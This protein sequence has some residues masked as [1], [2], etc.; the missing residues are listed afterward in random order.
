LAD[1]HITADLLRAVARGDISPRI[2]VEIGIDH[3]TSLCP[4]CREEFSAWQAEQ[5]I[6][7]I[8]PEM[9]MHA[10]PSVLQRHATDAEAK[11]KEAERD[12]EALAAL[13][14]STR[15]TRIRR[16]TKR[17]RGVV[18]AGKLLDESKRI[19]PGEP[20]RAFDLAQAAETVLLQTRAVPGISDF[21]ARAAAFQANALRAQGHLQDAEARF[22]F[23]RFFIQQQGVTDSALIAE[24]DCCEAALALDQRRLAD[25]EKLLNRSIHMWT[26]AGEPASAAHPMLTLGRL[27]ALQGDYGK[28]IELAQRAA[29]TAG[30]GDRRL[31]LYA[32]HNQA[33]YL[34]EAGAFETA[35]AVL[36]EAHDLYEEFPDAFTQHRLVWLEAKIA[37]GQGRLE[38]AEDSFLTV[39]QAFFDDAL[40][41]DAAL[42]SIDLAL[43]YARQGRTAELKSLAEQ[44]HLVFVSQEIHRE[45]TAALLLFQ[46]AARRDALTL[47]TL[48]EL[49]A[50]LRAARGNPTLR[51]RHPLD[52][53]GDLT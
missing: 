16:A 15:L 34:C 49:A 36:A 42:V 3:L 52:I 10:L 40:G 8:R 50:Y 39:R 47:E 43:L 25:A 20:Q 21:Y 1:V 37:V 4:H 5:R 18:L 31:S 12:F 27:H 24:I 48:E 29:E 14:H 53:P 32:R 46:E 7:A 35:A 19:V 44:M 11:R 41:Y 51:F 6:A 22:A 28:A 23:A 26:I 13:P 38:E 2:L 45:A 33:N 17:F 30:E 9:V